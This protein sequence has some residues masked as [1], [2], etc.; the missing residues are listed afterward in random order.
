[1]GA[2]DKESMHQEIG[3]KPLKKAILGEKQNQAV[4]PQFIEVGFMKK[5]FCWMAILSLGLLAS[6]CASYPKTGQ[7]AAIGAGSG[8]L[9]GAGISVATGGSGWAG[10]AIGGLAGTMAGALIGYHMDQSES[11]TAVTHSSGASTFILGNYRNCVTT[12]AQC[13]VDKRA[14]GMAEL[15]F[16]PDGSGN[17][18]RVQGGET[19]NRGYFSWSQEDSKIRLSFN[20][21]SKLIINIIPGG[22]VDFNGQY[23]INEAVVAK[24]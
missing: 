4:K 20:S 18:S 10:A 12:S 14:W 7:G 8:A 24:F 13:A 6:G 1:M 21:G 5:L 16:H 2:R 3:Q 22:V 19:H 15:F 9:L 17:R 23:Y 11:E